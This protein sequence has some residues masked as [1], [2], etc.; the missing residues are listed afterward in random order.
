MS[1]ILPPDKVCPQK[2][3]FVRKWQTKAEE[4]KVTVL[5]LLHGG[6]DNHKHLLNT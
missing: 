3:I 6:I 2:K 5:F 4:E 1:N